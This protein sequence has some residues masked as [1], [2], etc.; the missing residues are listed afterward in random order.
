MYVCIYM[1]IYTC[2]C[3]LARA[4]A[5]LHGGEEDGGRGARGCRYMY[6]NIYSYIDRYIDR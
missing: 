6:I 3:G 2:I 4:C 1:Y 5:H